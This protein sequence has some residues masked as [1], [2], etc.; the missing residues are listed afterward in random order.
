MIGD[1]AID[2]ATGRAAGART[3]GCAWGLRGIEE[4]RAAGADV[5]VEAPA[6]IPLLVLGAQRSG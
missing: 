6:E 2:I 1:S 3:V 5:L 4:L